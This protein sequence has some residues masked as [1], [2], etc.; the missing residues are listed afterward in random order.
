MTIRVIVV[1]DDNM[2]RQSLCRIVNSTKG[3]KVVAAAAN[4]SEAIERASSVAHDVVVIDYYLPDQHGDEVTRQIIA[5]NPNEVILGISG[6]ADLE[7]VNRMTE[8][9]ALGFLFKAEDLKDLICAIRTLAA[10]GLFFKSENVKKALAT[11]P[12]STEALIKLARLTTREREI[13]E[14]KIRGW[15]NHSI[16]SRLEIAN[17]TVSGHFS[18]LQQKLGCSDF[19]E[20]MKFAIKAKLVD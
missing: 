10:G 19:A 2:V 8:A 13:L 5:R 4:A 20:L 7:C 3:M 1:D 18:S 6:F 11:I 9:G 15:Q 16:A 12:Q 14:F 17:S